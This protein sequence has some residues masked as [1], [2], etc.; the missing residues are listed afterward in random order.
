M[1]VI[2]AYIL[3]GSMALA[4]ALG[5]VM[6]IDH[7]SPHFP[8][9]ENVHVRYEF[10]VENKSSAPIESVVLNLFS[11]GF[12]AFGQRLASYSVYPSSDERVVVDSEA[13]RTE[14]SIAR[15]SPF[16]GLPVS[17]GAEVNITGQI[18]VDSLKILAK[19]P[20]SVPNEIA[21]IS[22]SLEGDYPSLVMQWL[23]QNIR[24]SHYRPKLRRSTDILLSG[25]G[26]CT[27]F[28]V[29][30]SEL[31]W[32]RN[33]PNVVVGGFIVQ[34]KSELLAAANYHNWLYFNYDGQWILM[35]PINGLLSGNV[36][37]YLVFEYLDG[38]LQKSRFYANNNN[39]SVVMK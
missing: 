10:Y 3:A 35:D 6:A 2:K 19:R 34:G 31:L 32:A 22:L 1:P 37:H 18:D 17:I 13:S 25:N 36:D 23:K 14:L 29:V 21:D 9:V 26:D 5:V 30:A 11:P 7:T 12:S 24:A 4:A 27:D 33:I 15:L 20:D 8:G 38:G 16:Q 28:S 39:V